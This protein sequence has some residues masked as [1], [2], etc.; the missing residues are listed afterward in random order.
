MEPD[1]YIEFLIDIIA[2]FT[3]RRELAFRRAQPAKARTVPLLSGRKL[4]G[5]CR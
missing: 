2:G 4:P 5:F 3:A 1:D